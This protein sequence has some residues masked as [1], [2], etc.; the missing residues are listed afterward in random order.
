MEAGDDRVLGRRRVAVDA[1]QRGGRRL[2]EPLPGSG[3]LALQRGHLGLLL[4]EQPGGLNPTASGGDQGICSFRL[5]DNG[6]EPSAEI[7]V[8]GHGEG[9]RRDLDLDLDLGV[10]SPY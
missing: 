3:S 8:V 1:C 7:V 4:E 2:R 6:V 9:G 5:L 10:A